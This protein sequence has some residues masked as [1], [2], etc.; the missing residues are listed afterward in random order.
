MWLRPALVPAAV[1]FVP[2]VGHLI[3][4]GPLAAM[5]FGGLQGAVLVGG[6]SALA[7]ALM[8]IGIPRDSVL[9][10]ILGMQ[11]PAITRCA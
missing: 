10:Y 1:M 8:S 7:G 9:R 11:A 4:L 2:V 3:V 6:V 5:L